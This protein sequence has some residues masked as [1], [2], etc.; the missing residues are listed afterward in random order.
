[1][2]ILRL[3][4]VGVVATTILSLG[5]GMAERASQPS[6]RERFDK[7]FADGNFKDALEGYRRLA[8]DPK[9][10]PDRVGTDLGQAVQCLARLGRHDEIDT[11]REAVIAVHQGNWRLLQA[12]ALSYLE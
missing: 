1:M 6:G 2:V 8:L 12:A 3:S 4:L 11:F 7:L 9:T 5:V 10:E